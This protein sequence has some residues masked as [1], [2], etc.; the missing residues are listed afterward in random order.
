MR[1]KKL[2]VTLGAAGLVVAATESAS[3]NP[4]R[5]QGRR[6]QRIQAHG[7]WSKPMSPNPG[8]AAGY[9]RAD[10]SR[11]PGP[12]GCRSSPSRPPLLPPPTRMTAPTT[13]AITITRSPQR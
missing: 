1:M 13:A 12:A 4:L 5:R 9:G 8:K 7:G 11:H 2:I 3:A 6:C 10:P